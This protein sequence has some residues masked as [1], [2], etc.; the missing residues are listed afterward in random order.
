M[1]LVCIGGSALLESQRAQAVGMP[2][3]LCFSA[4][5]HSVACSGCPLVSE[6]ALESSLLRA[7]CDTGWSEQGSAE[8]SGPVSLS[9]WFLL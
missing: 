5:V 9:A 4:T 3:P 1:T 8:A 6:F 7:S 2:L